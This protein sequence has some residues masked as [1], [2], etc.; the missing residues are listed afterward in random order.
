MQHAYDM[1]SY[2][3]IIQYR[4]LY[5]EVFEHGIIERASFNEGG[6]FSPAKNS[7][8]RALLTEC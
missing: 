8:Y 4:M 6:P 1:P 3:L 7:Y 2:F 5:F